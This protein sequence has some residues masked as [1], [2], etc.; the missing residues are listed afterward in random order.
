MKLK[1]QKVEKTPK[2]CM[3][4]ELSVGST[5]VYGKLEDMLFMR[6]DRE[7]VKGE[8]AAVGLQD[9]LESTF[10]SDDVVTPVDG[11]LS[12]SYARYE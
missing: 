5:F 6:T 3:L 10:K 2:S 4:G 7:N 8:V 11:T 9:G 12:W 1:M